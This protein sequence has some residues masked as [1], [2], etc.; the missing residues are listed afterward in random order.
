MDFDIERRVLVDR[1]DVLDA[2]AAALDRREEVLAVV[3]AAVDPDAALE[4][5]RAAFGWS[6][7]Q[8]HAVLSLQLL[9]FSVRQR[10]RINEDRESVRA[11][12]AA[13]D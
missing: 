9:R 3:A 1:L 6:D 7:S 11:M 2:M 8:A 13:G 10:E 5:L 12:L 4:E